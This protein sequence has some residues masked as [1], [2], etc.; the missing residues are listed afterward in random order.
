MKKVPF[1][2]AVTAAE[3]APEMDPVLLRGSIESAFHK[4]AELGYDAIEV[5]LRSAEAI[6]AERMV[7]LA[8]ETGVAVAAVATG[9]AKREDG[10][11]L[12][13]DDPAARA[14]AVERLKGFVDWAAVVGCIIIVGS[15]RGNLP[16]KKNREIP[17]AR[18]HECL[19][20]VARYAE[21][22]GVTIVVEAINR[23]ENNYCN[24]AEETAEYVRTF[25]SPALLPH[26]D[27][28]HMNIEEADM[29]EAI[30]KTGK[31]LGHIHFADNNRHA[32]GEGCLDFGAVLDALID[33]DFKG[34]VS[35][36]CLP[37]PDGVTA[38]ERSI[39][40]IK[41]LLQE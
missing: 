26:L 22:K 15:M 40:Y 2:F 13:D 3:Q 4:A 37:L 1:K 41:S 18:M 31:E 9:L 25:H 6:P 34:Y 7:E 20:E 39:R 11:C 21:E 35:V 23:Y 8:K 29:V 28:F 36:E 27:T 12:I 17:D 19:G 16:D 38:A 24:T 30:R 33:I 10:L 5:H 32:C 14:A